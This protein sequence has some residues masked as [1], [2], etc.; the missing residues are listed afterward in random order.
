MEMPEKCELCPRRCGARRQAGERG[1][2]GAGLLPRVA[3]AALHYWE[4]PCIS[5]ERGSGTVFFSGCTMR[6]RFCQNREISRGEAGAEISVARLAEI[7]LELQ[8][9]GAENVNL[10]TPMHYAP[11]IT[12][13]VHSARER[14]LALPV[15]WNTGG[16]ETEE[17]VAMVEDCADIWL[18]DLKYRDDLLALRFSGAP[19][20]FETAAAALRQMV[21][22][23]GAPVFDGRGMMKRGVIVRHLMLPG[24]GDDTRAVLEYL[25]GEYGDDI[26]ISIMNQYTPMGEDADY[27]ELHRA[28]TDDEYEAALDYAMELGIENAFIQEGGTVSESFVPPFDL[29]G[30]LGPA[31]KTDGKGDI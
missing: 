7:F 22:Q 6:C 13:A 20:Y 4:E 5:G 25:H 8:E 16:W 11:Q 23:T 27:P 24:H 2:C 26:W 30:V 3:R 31:G 15:V 17:S 1:F 14:G 18:T 28:V 19:G 21:R 10:V 9:S 12:E 29:S